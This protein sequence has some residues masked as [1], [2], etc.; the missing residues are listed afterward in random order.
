MLI[1]FFFVVHPICEEALPLK[2]LHKCCEVLISQKHAGNLLKNL[3]SLII[4]EKGPNFLQNIWQ[5]SGLSFNDFIVPA[6]DAATF[7]KDNVRYLS[8]F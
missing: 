4:E 6:Q 2:T 8:F 5:S 7:V 1:F 3:F